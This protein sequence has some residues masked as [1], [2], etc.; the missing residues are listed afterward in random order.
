MKRKVI[1]TI[2]LA[3]F[4]G[5]SVQMPVFAQIDPVPFMPAP[6]M[7]VPLSPQFSPSFLKG[8]VVHP[9]DPFKFDFIIYKGDKHLSET[10]KKVEYTKLTKYFLASLA[11]P[12]ENQWVNLSPYEKDR[13]IKDDFGATLMGRDL[14]AQDYL[15]KQ[16]TASLIYPESRLGQEFWK[17]VYSQAQERFGTTNIPMNTFNKVWILPDDALIYEKGHTA[18]VLKNHLKVMLE[19]D[20]LALSKHCVFGDSHH[21]CKEDPKLGLPGK[22]KNGNSPQTHSIA[23]KIVRDIVLP[24][25]QK[26]VNE[27]ENFAALRQV[28]SGMV[29]AAWFKRE[30]K[31]SLIGKIYADKAKVRGVDQDPRTNEAIYQQYLKAYKKGVFNFIKEDADSLTNETTPRKYFSGG[32][33]NNYLKGPLHIEHAASAGEL[34]EIIKDGRDEDLAQVVVN[35]TKPDAAMVGIPSEKMASYLE[36]LI[37]KHPPK[38]DT[39]NLDSY[40]RSLPQDERNAYFREEAADRQ[41]EVNDRWKEVIEEI[42]RPFRGGFAQKQSLIGRINERIMRPESAL[43]LGDRHAITPEAGN[44]LIGI[45]N[46][47]ASSHPS[48]ISSIGISLQ[49]FSALAQSK[50]TLRPFTTKYRTDLRYLYAVLIANGGVRRDAAN[51]REDRAMRGEEDKAGQLRDFIVHQTIEK[52]ELQRPQAE[53]LARKFD[54]ALGRH[55]LGVYLWGGFLKLEITK[56]QNLDSA[57]EYKGDKISIVYFPGM[58]DAFMFWDPK[59]GGKVIG[60]GILARRQWESGIKTFNF[61]FQIFEPYRHAGYGD[62]ALSLLLYSFY[63]DGSKEKTAFRF[64]RVK[65]PVLAEKAKEQ[66]LAGFLIR[67]GFTPEGDV[68]DLTNTSF[69]LTVDAAMSSKGIEPDQRL[70]F[71]Q[72]RRKKLFARFRMA[73]AGALSGWRMGGASALE[74]MVHLPYGLEDMRR[75][76]K[77]SF[78]ASYSLLNKDLNGMYA[79]TIDQNELPIVF[80]LKRSQG[81]YLNVYGTKYYFINFNDSGIHVLGYNREEELKAFYR[82]IHEVVNR[83]A[84]LTPAY[85]KYA[86]TM[87]SIQP[88]GL[89]YLSF[90]NSGEEANAA[91][92]KLLRLKRTKSQF[93]IS[94]EG[95]KPLAAE[96][97]PEAKVIFPDESDAQQRRSLKQIWSLVNI[98]L[99]NSK[100]RPI[101]DHIFDEVLKEIDAFIDTETQNGLLGTERLDTIMLA[102]LRLR[103][104][105]KGR[106]G[107]FSRNAVKVA[108]VMV[109]PYQGEGSTDT[110]FFQR[111]RFL[112]A[113]FDVPLVFDEGESGLY[114]TGKRWAH[115]HFNLSIPPD[116]V[117]FSKK[118]QTGGMYMTELYF[119]KELG[120][121]NPGWGGS[122]EGIIRTTVDDETIRRKYLVQRINELGEYCL[123]KLRTLTAEVNR[124]HPNFV[125]QVKGWGLALGLDFPEKQ[126]RDDVWEQAVRR[127]LI[128]NKVGER[129]LQISLRYDTKTYTVNEALGILKEAMEAVVAKKV[130][131]DSVTRGEGKEDRQVPSVFFKEG[132]ISFVGTNMI[133]GS[134][135]PASDYQQTGTRLA[136]PFVP[137]NVP[138]EVHEAGGRIYPLRLWNLYAATFNDETQGRLMVIAAQ[139]KARFEK[140][141]ALW[142]GLTADGRKSLAGQWKDLHDDNW[143]GPPRLSMLDEPEALSLPQAV[144]ETADKFKIG[145]SFHATFRG[146]EMSSGSEI[147]TGIGGKGWVRVNIASL[148]RVELMKDGQKHY[149]M[150]ASG[151]SLA[152]KGEAFYKPFG[153]KAQ[154]RP[155]FKVM[156]KRFGAVLEPMKEDEND[157]MVYVPGEHLDEFLKFYRENA[158]NP[159]YFEPAIETAYRELR[160]ELTGAVDDDVPFLPQDVFERT[161]DAAMKGKEEKTGPV[162]TIT[163]VLISQPDDFMSWLGIDF[164]NKMYRMPGSDE[165]MTEPLYEQ[166]SRQNIR[167]IRDRIIRFI[168]QGPRTIFNMIYSEWAREHHLIRETESMGIKLDMPIPYDDLTPKQKRD[169]DTYIYTSYV[170]K[171][172]RLQVLKQILSPLMNLPSLRYDPSPMPAELERQVTIAGAKVVLKLMPDLTDGD[173]KDI[174]GQSSTADKVKHLADGVDRAMRGDDLAERIVE[175]VKQIGAVMDDNGVNYDLVIIGSRTSLDI[176]AISKAMMKAQQ[177][178]A[179]NIFHNGNLS[180]RLYP[181]SSIRGKGIVKA[182]LRS[183]AAYIP[184]GTVLEGNIGDMNT[185]EYLQDNLEARGEKVFHKKDGGPWSGFE[186]VDA[187]TGPSQVGW[188]D[189]MTVQGK[190]L[191]YLLSK[192]FGFDL[193]EISVGVPVD[194]AQPFIRPQNRKGTAALRQ[195]LLSPR[196]IGYRAI[197]RMGHGM[198]E[199]VAD[200]RNKE[201]EGFKPVDPELL[202]FK[203]D[204]LRERLE[205]IVGGIFNEY[206]M[207]MV[208]LVKKKD[209]QFYLGEDEAK[210]RAEIEQ[211]LKDTGEASYKVTQKKLILKIERMDNAMA[212]PAVRG[213]VA[214]GKAVKGIEYTP[215]EFIQE[216]KLTR[217]W[218]YKIYIAS[219]SIG[220]YRSMNLNVH[221]DAEGSYVLGTSLSSTRKINHSDPASPLIIFFDFGNGRYGID[222]RSIIKFKETGAYKKIPSQKVGVLTDAELEK[223]RSFEQWAQAHPEEVKQRSLTELSRRFGI[224]LRMTQKVLV[225]LGLNSKGMP[226]ID[227]AMSAQKPQSMASELVRLRFDL[228]YMRIVAQDIINTHRDRQLLSSLEKDFQE[229]Q[230]ILSFIGT[231]KALV[232][233]QDFAEHWIYTKQDLEQFLNKEKWNE[234][235]GKLDEIEKEIPNPQQVS[236]EIVDQFNRL[237]DIIEKRPAGTDIGDIIEYDAEALGIDEPGPVNVEQLP[238]NFEVLTST[239]PISAQEARERVAAQAGKDILFNGNIGGEWVFYLVKNPDAAMKGED[240]KE[241]PEMNIFYDEDKLNAFVDEIVQSISHELAKQGLNHE[242][243]LEAHVRREVLQFVQKYGFPSEKAVFPDYE[244]AYDQLNNLFRDRGRLIGVYRRLEFFDSYLRVKNWERLKWRWPQ[245]LNLSIEIFKKWTGYHFE[246]ERFKLRNSLV[247]PQN[248]TVNSNILLPHGMTFPHLIIHEMWHAFGRTP[249]P[250][251]LDE[252]MTEYLTK[253]LLKRESEP[254]MGI[255][256]RYGREEGMTSM[257][258]D[259]IGREPL[260]VSYMT[261][262]KSYVVNALGKNG[263][264]AWQLLEALEMLGENRLS[265]SKVYLEMILKNLD[266]EEHLYEIARDMTNFMDLTERKPY[267]VYPASFWNRIYVLTLRK[268]MRNLL[269][270]D[271]P[272]R[273]PV[274]IPETAGKLEQ[275]KAE[276]PLNKVLAEAIDSYLRRANIDPAEGVNRADGVMRGQEDAAMMGQENA[277][278]LEIPGKTRLRTWVKDHLKEAEKWSH[279][280]VAVEFGVSLSTVSKVYIEMGLFRDGNT[281]KLA[282][283]GPYRSS[284][285]INSEAA[286]QFT[287][288]FQEAVIAKMNK[289]RAAGREISY[290]KIARMANINNH[291]KFLSY[292]NG[293]LIKGQRSYQLPRTQ[294][295]VEDLEKALDVPGE[296][297]PLWKA[298]KGLDEADKA[299]RVEKAGTKN[300]RELAIAHP[301]EVE[302]STLSELAGRFGIGNTAVWRVLRGL[303]LSSHGRKIRDVGAAIAPQSPR[304]TNPA[305]ALEFTLKLQKAMEAKIAKEKAEGKTIFAK[306]IALSAGISASEFSYYVVGRIKNEKRTYELPLYSKIVEALEKAL[307]VPGEL[308]PL[309]KAAKGLDKAQASYGGIDLNSANLNLRIKRDGHGV[310]LPLSQQD[311]AQLSQIEGLDP[312]ILSIKP[313]NQTAVFAE[314]V[315]H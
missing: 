259:V 286:G 9:E 253:L 299:M 28:F 199:R 183:L 103:E 49:E 110:R 25:L 274:L 114:L 108:G 23:A 206:G 5:T 211:W 66:D 31:E 34:D 203:A 134:G 29:L 69:L 72:L 312:V 14:L 65:H 153:G 121:L 86:H 235:L 208:E 218:E 209:A 155:A 213:E 3:A 38:R 298:A 45:V 36:Q 294:Q 241:K 67:R 267:A 314:L 12:D 268:R 228:D 266:S 164:L 289:E 13:I 244:R 182:V 282:P 125:S 233:Q 75:P 17:R 176:K 87:K 191:G 287:K 281:Y 196:A 197:R 225:K 280:D 50:E 156:L 237:I 80:D 188:R 117:T 223:K 144:T 21:F 60:Y 51:G 154:Y 148:L 57:F 52:H 30:L 167:L 172:T 232:F 169:W 246:T 207:V 138:A 180:L 204:V 115:E 245:R 198:A 297:L 136:Y 254:S 173:A 88:E 139:E 95:G 221:Q 273:K 118:A 308:L 135:D 1:I 247:M 212:A 165:I 42:M 147:K 256:V 124:V 102:I 288:K 122:E 48:G 46:L 15:L 301:D 47:L 175:G 307:D 238:S 181:D 305:K 56:H 220:E 111:L 216:L 20:Y 309:W 93:M 219:K 61:N 291:S 189:I 4:L 63:R 284:R 157:L 163:L 257:L 222:Q 195:F 185:W 277:Q 150:Q 302:Q 11:I 293:I 101:N 202:I 123:V 168:D 227:R 158:D 304:I 44:R 71:S 105:L 137:M 234:M 89:D 200:V 32:L 269:E 116:I 64:L 84:F 24:E 91:A 146:G 315:G 74:P 313:A 58:T 186:V 177:V 79:Y 39:K 81:D 271:M 112:T 127:G 78:S 59:D 300:L 184:S 106:L 100:N 215:G 90:F 210:T 174:Y 120:E 276:N 295:I 27:G 239:G 272:S 230:R 132:R 145:D 126:V 68:N 262:D 306:D 160:E 251:W 33:A 99:P 77:E 224:S 8:I 119:G 171:E 243:L 194:V 19:E 275:L 292:L 18:Y 159:E 214:Q 296:L 128:L 263:L 109:E 41:R 142:A 290:A 311:L 242:Y 62:E 162:S 133:W 264:K 6:G 10:Q 16:I 141:V 131:Q 73:L 261:G 35:A 161:S 205:D 229:I 240:Q 149:L 248:N 7:M 92:I 140:H 217:G 231:P 283:K 166:I 303:G 26:E 285:I 113:L 310:M 82:N 40:L 187:V 236:P 170:A 279:P 265:I 76:L 94:F 22:S 54:E 104:N 97:F 278:R 250:R 83:T 96:G 192:Y 201:E 152:D 151:D 130:G 270:G 178:L 37:Y 2:V 143:S 252:G 55:G 98:G 226:E 53:D 249:Y 85:A 43:L 258:S 190:T 70:T 255:S 179:I 260:I 107:D 129:T 193:T